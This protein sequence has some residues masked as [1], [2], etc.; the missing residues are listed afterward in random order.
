M[1][2]V[3][4][5]DPSTITSVSTELERR[6][7]ARMDFIAP[8]SGLSFSSSGE[9]GMSGQ[10][11]FRVG[12]RFFLRWHE[13]EKYLDEE[14]QY[15]RDNPD[16]PVRDEELKIEP[17]KAPELKLSKT[18]YSQLL[19]RMEIPARLAKQMVPKYKVE[20]AFSDFMTSILRAR[21]DKFMLRYLDGQVRAVLSPK[22]RIIDGADLFFASLNCLKHH[23]VELWDCKLTDDRFELF[24][25]HRGVGERLVR[26]NDLGGGGHKF[27]KTESPDGDLHNAALRISNSDTGCG[28]SAVSLAVMRE[29]C[30]NFM[31][32]GDML[33]MVHL[34]RDL[35]NESF[36]LSER[37]LRKQGELDL[38][39]LA[40]AVSACFSQEKF[41]GVM[42]KLRGAT[43][44]SVEDNY[45]EV[46][47]AATGHFGLSRDTEKSIL[48]EF[49]RAGDNTLF[50][51]AQAAT[52]AAKTLPPEQGALVQG[53]VSRMIESKS[54]GSWVKSGQAKRTKEDQEVLV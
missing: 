5:M 23:D 13:A 43:E 47:Q 49:L 54:L 46:I 2:L 19:T 39:K 20:G 18:A 17:Q 30:S 26:N 33:T 42:E 51:V 53:G 50:G 37:T 16:A 22:Y 41:E 35:S 21:K 1:H 3:G 44:V 12:Q 11:G 29:V 8:V 4:K 40:D 7:D 52:D 15:R 9:L 14:Q 32:W 10:D 45:E 34:G 27:S 36:V 38:H 6:R 31:V 25:T 28:K 48:T 24:A